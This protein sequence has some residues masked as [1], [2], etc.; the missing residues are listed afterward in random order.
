LE[1][2]MSGI[3]GS[4]LNCK[5]SGIVG[6]LGTDG[7]VLMS[8][9]VGKSAV[10]EDA[11]GFTVSD[12][13]GATALAEEPAITDEIAISDGGTLKRLDIQHLM[14]VP[15]ISCSKNATVTSETSTQNKLTWNVED[16]SVAGTF[17]TT[18]NR[19]TPGVAGHYCCVTNIRYP[20]AA[21]ED[22]KLNG[23][24]LRIS[25]GLSQGSASSGTSLYA[26]GD[27][28]GGWNSGYQYD[29]TTANS[30]DPRL[31][32]VFWLDDDHYVETYTYQNTGDD[33]DVE[34]GY[35]SMFLWRL[36][37]MGTTYDS[38]LPNS[39]IRLKEDI[40]LVRKSPTGI[41]IYSF[42]YKDKKGRYE[43]VMAQEVPWASKL[44][45]S[46][47]YAVDYSKVDVDF[48]KLKEKT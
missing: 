3:V 5:G 34:A 23:L 2:N 22:G 13:T 38:T 19:W 32:L 47:Y 39:D 14:G 11:G 42:K 26:R 46:G 1:I 27:G 8:S 9:G 37:G 33:F 48:K 12:I 43:G 41:N 10:F 40:E 30:I 4:R 21:M 16:K 25:G 45:N 17:D 24:K 18:N 31:F 36:A 6:S 29:F 15:F 28:G 44:T 7:Q 35:S 20:A